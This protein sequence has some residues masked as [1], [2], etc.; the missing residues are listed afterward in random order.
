MGVRV[1]EAGGRE[2]GNRAWNRNDVKKKA[3]ERDRRWKGMGRR[4]GR[5]RFTT[6]TNGFTLPIEMRGKPKERLWVSL[7]WQPT[8]GSR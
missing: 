8:E 3:R 1:K 2:R 5:Q 7:H 4:E 6:P